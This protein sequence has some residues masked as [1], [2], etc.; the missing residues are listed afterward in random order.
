MNAPTIKLLFGARL[1][2]CRLDQEITQGELA[3]ACMLH[4]QQISKIERGIHSPSVT[5]VHAIL[6]ILGPKY[7]DYLMGITDD[8]PKTSLPTDQTPPKTTADPEQQAPGAPDHL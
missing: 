1:R 5:T 8:K 2:E 3:H 6:E 7:L 4:T